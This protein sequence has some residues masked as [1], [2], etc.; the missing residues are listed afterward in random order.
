MVIGPDKGAS[1]EVQGWI[2]F[3]DNLC[4]QIVPLL[5]MKM[6][7]ISLFLTYVCSNL[8]IIVRNVMKMHVISLYL[9]VNYYAEVDFA[10]IM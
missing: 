10:H 5:P 2:F 3:I 8:P 9:C 7:L 6:H 4:N 1:S